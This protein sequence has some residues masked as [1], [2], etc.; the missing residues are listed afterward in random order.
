MSHTLSPAK[1]QPEAAAAAAVVAQVKWSSFHSA[2]QFR[3][4][5]Q[6]TE[7]NTGTHDAL[8]YGT[9]ISV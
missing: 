6:V 3:S 5:T 9:K 2:E 8:E 4:L 1:V 7:Y